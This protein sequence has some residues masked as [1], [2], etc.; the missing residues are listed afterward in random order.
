MAYFRR[1]PQ[2]QTQW[3]V[4]DLPDEV[5]VGSKVS[6][7]KRDGSVASV[8]ISGFVTA[9]TGERLATFTRK[10]RGPA[11]PTTCPHCGGAL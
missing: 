5:E 3:V 4:A 2:D 10:G 11:R 6:V 8:V 7:A 9:E 1:N